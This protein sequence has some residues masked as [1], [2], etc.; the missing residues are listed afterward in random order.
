MAGPVAHSGRRVVGKQTHQK[1]GTSPAPGAASNS[2][3]PDITYKW[4][5][6]DDSWASGTN[7]YVQQETDCQAPATII[8]NVYMQQCTSWDFHDSYCTGTWKGDSGGIHCDTSSPQL[9]LLCPNGNALKISVSAGYAYRSDG[10]VTT[11]IPNTV[12]PTVTGEYF[13]YPWAISG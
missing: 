6:Y 1:K 13:G 4:Y 2:E 11:T 12:P 3:S 10:I 7:F 8:M 5:I 9:V